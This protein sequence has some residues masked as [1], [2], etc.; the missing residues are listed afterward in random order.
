MKLDYRLPGITM[1]GPIRAGC[2]VN[3]GIKQEMLIPAES[4]NPL[5]YSIFLGFQKESVHVV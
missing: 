1:I 3:K 5:I 2:P 4:T